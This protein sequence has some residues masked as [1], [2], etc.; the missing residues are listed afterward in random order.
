[1]KEPRESIVLAFLQSPFILNDKDGANISLHLTNMQMETHCTHLW[2]KQDKK[3]GPNL[4][5]I[6]IIKN[7]SQTPKSSLYHSAFSVWITHVKNSN[8]WWQKFLRYW[9]GTNPQLIITR[10]LGEVKRWS[11]TLHDTYRPNMYQ[12]L[13][14]NYTYKSF[15]IFLFCKGSPTT[16]S[17]WKK[18]KTWFV[19]NKS[20]WCNHSNHLLCPQLKAHFHLWV[21]DSTFFLEF[22][23]H[24]WKQGFSFS[25]FRSQN[26]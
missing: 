19:L 12:I 5:L 6:M 1:M 24:T 21:A 10:K 2:K 13:C 17:K 23:Y 22:P 25:T 3:Q 26:I 14:T 4:H 18:Y 20:M 9:C 7:V 15:Q 8:F 16:Q 11:L